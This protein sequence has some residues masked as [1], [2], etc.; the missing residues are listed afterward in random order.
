[1]AQKHALLSPSSAARW[2]KCHA[3]PLMESNYSGDDA[4]EFAAEGTRA[5]ECAARALICDAPARDDSL[6]PE[7]LSHVQQY[8]DFV[9]RAASAPG[10]R[11]YVEHELDI[12]G[13]TGELGAIGTADAIIVAPD[14]LHIIDLKFGRGVRVSALENPQLKIYAAAALREFP[15]HGARIIKTTIFQP[16]VQNI[17][18]AQYK[19]ENIVGFTYDLQHIARRCMYLI[20]LGEA[21]GED[22]APSEETCRFCKARGECDALARSV[23]KAVGADFAAL[24]AAENPDEFLPSGE[25][26]AAAYAAVGMVELW[27][28]AVCAAAE[29]RLLDGHGLPGYKL[30]AGRRGA[31]Q[32]ADIDA[33]AKEMERL[34]LGDIYEKKLVTPAAAERLFKAAGL[35]A[36]YWEP[37]RALIVQKDAKPVIA[38][39]SD[40]R[41]ALDMKE[42]ILAA[43]D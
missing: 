17:D 41:A 23:Q 9:R 26:L 21:A 8:V 12:T 5:H 31:R 42:D 39:E 35:E 10:A 16:R 13:V 27:C 33:A 24:A 11:L 32:W 19:Q 37:L 29:K 43:F 14:S 34:Q 7:D 40:E 20:G 4:G 28:K 18:T 1:M 15:A 6:A 2:I 3:A 36:D 38:P 22:F 30:V 25:K